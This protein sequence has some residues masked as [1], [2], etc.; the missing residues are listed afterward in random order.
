LPSVRRLPSDII[1]DP[2]VYNFCNEEK[3]C[4]DSIEIDGTTNRI[5]RV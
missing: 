1:C 4:E 3:S 2:L 5:K